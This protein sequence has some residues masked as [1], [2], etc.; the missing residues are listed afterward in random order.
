ME[1]VVD[2]F[3]HR[4]GG[5][6][7]YL[8]ELLPLLAREPTIKRVSLVVEP[9]SRLA[10]S[11]ASSAVD[12]HV[13][14]LMP[15][16]SV[17][18]RVLW[19]AVCLSR[20]AANAVVLSPNAMLPLALPQPVV[21]V[22]HNLLPFV[23]RR[24]RQLIQRAAITRTLARATATIFVSNEMQRRV[25]HAGCTPRSSH[26]I[27]HGVSS[28][29]FESDPATARESIV[30]VA[31]NYPHK[32]IGL[33]V[34]AWTLLGPGRPP[35][36]LIGSGRRVPAIHG[37]TQEAGLSASAVAATLRSAAVV[38]LPSSAE[39][40][41]L[42]A[43]EALASEAPL[44]VSDLSVFREVTGGHA[45]FVQGESPD[46]WAATIRAT[47]ENPPQTARGR[48]WAQEFRWSAT[49]TRTAAVLVSAARLR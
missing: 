18:S 40:F 42:P 17:V 22:P 9:A 49:A 20:V 7:T 4:F 5:S 36:R 33:L 16:E 1:V 44:V 39:S 14:R 11:L 8:Q 15:S 13:V 25:A 27:P 26:V 34:K 10:S 29:F 24:W 23:S 46:N 38:V 41:G 21:A 28:V 30:C 31:D 2:G 35:L 48:S 45:R 3:S 37:L 19:E 12:I 32:R 47:L 43:L 6:V